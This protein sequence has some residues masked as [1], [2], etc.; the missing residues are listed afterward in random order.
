MLVQQLVKQVLIK[1]AGA[2]NQQIN[3]I[4]PNSHI[5]DKYVYYQVVS[6][7]FQAQIQAKASST[8]LP[9]LNKGKFLK[10]RFGLAPFPIQRAIV[11]KIEELFS[12][13]DSGIADLTKA[14]EQLKVYRQAVLKKAFEGEYDERFLQSKNDIRT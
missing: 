3:A 10:L 11:A 1:K 4:V 8:T 5:L 9:I 14:Q 7:L 2:F 6:P 12:S 13:L